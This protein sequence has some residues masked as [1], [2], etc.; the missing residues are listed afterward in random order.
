[1]EVNYQCTFS[2]YREAMDSQVSGPTVAYFLAIGGVFLL[3]IAGI[4]GVVTHG[5]PG[6]GVPAVVGGLFLILPLLLRIARKFWIAQDFRKHSSFGRGAHMVV[7]G[8]SLK[9]E[10]GLVRRE[11]KWPAITCYRETENL[12]ILH[13][14]PRF[15]RIFPKRAFSGQDLDEFRQLL[16]AKNITR[17]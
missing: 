16:S 13:E 10:D 5:H 2:D 17:L 15:L 8:E 3:I 11:S 6:S 9:V 12:F 4:S 14:G 7:D 1:M